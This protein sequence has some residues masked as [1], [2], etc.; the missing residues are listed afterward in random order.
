[1]K[2]ILAFVAV[3]VSYVTA[4]H[5]PL[6]PAGLIPRS[7]KARDN[8]TFNG[9]T[10]HKIVVGASGQIVGYTFNGS[11]FTPNPKANI[12]E[13]G[14]VASWL[15]FKEPNLLYAND[16]NSNATRLFNYNRQTG[17]LSKQLASWNASSGV[18]HL[19][20]T[21]DKNRLVGSSYG[22]G[23]VDIWNSSDPSG[24]LQLIQQ[25][26]L[27]GQHGPDV[28]SQTQLRA[29][30]AVLDPSGRFFVINDLGGDALHILDSKDDSWTITNCISITPPRSGPRHGVFISLAGDSKATHYVVVN[31]IASTLTLFQVIYTDSSLNLINPQTVSTFGELLPPANA[32]S[33]R[34]AEIMVSHSGAV[35]I[36]VS[37]RL[38]GNQTDTI[39]RFALEQPDNRT[40]PVVNGTTPPPAGSPVLRFQGHID[41]GGFKPRHMSLSKDKSEEIMWIANTDGQDGLQAVTRCGRDGG[42][43]GH[44]LMAAQPLGE[45]ANTLFSA[46]GQDF[47]PQFVAEF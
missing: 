43:A 19:A 22:Q 1:M 15:A 18:V 29:H 6:H 45:L 28:N 41:T 47:G 11:T 39:S 40:V 33:A 9:T 5:G 26:Q 7:I 25:V 3:A 23:Q 21:Q 10:A 20:F 34:A 38:T 8:S 31:E 17:E 44:C 24:A 12:S 13:P 16:E 32:S 42:S 2:S 30:Q 35:N 37:N 4:E 46:Q 27:T 14:R 36:Y